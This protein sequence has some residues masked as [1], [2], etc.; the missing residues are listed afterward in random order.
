MQVLVALTYLVNGH[1]QYNYP[2]PEGDNVIQT[3]GVPVLQHNGVEINR[4]QYEQPAITAQIPGAQIPKIPGQPQLT[5]YLQ[6]PQEIGY[7]QQPLIQ[8]H[9]YVH[10]P[11]P[12][13]EEVTA[14]PRPLKVPPREKHYKIIFVKVPSPRA[15]PP[16]VIPTQPAKEEKTLVYVLVK[17]PEAPAEIVLPTPVPTQ[18]S[19][20]EVYFIRYKS[21]EASGVGRVNVEG[22]QTVVPESTTLPAFG[23]DSRLALTPPPVPAYLPVQYRRNALADMHL[24]I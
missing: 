20:P 6:Q 1:P 9:V 16:V 7:Q 15:R 14:K 2:R 4:E 17:K 5:G 12:D 11:P 21:K 10:V 19:K 8:K 24:H 18:P 23:D 3:G 13:F 22:V